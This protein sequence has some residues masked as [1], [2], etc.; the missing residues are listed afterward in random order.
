MVER[1]ILMDM[2]AYVALGTVLVRNDGCNIL[3]GRRLRIGLKVVN[4][5]IILF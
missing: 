2:E 4:I 1:G 5:G 3:N